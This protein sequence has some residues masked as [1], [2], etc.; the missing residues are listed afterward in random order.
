VSVSGYRRT[1]LLT[2][3]MRK[4]DDNFVFVQQVVQHVFY[5][6]VDFWEMVEMNRKSMGAKVI[7]STEK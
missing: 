6:T 4:V 2:Y 5:A 3:L 7:I 1:Q